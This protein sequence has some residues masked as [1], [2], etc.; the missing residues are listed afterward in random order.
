VGCFN[1]SPYSPHWNP[2]RDINND[3]IIDLFD[4]IVLAANYGKSWTQ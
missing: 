4:A 2:N 3:G 1:S